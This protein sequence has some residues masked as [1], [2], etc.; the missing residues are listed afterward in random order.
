MIHVRELLPED[1]PAVARIESRAHDRSLTDGP[2]EHRERLTAALAESSNLSFGVFDDDE[3]VGYVLCYGFEPTAFADEQGNVL[4]VEDAAITPEYRPALPRLLKRFARHIHAYFPGVW[5]EAHA[6][7]RVLPIWR[8][9]DGL[10]ARHGFRFRRCEKTGE[11]LHGQARYALRWEPL[12]RGDTTAL[13]DMLAELP[14]H[15]P[16]PEQADD[17]V[18][19]VVRRESDWDVLEDVWDA[20]LLATPDHTAFQCYKYQR[21]WWRHFGGDS[22]LVIVLVLER[23]AIVGIAPLRTSVVRHYGR[24]RRELGFIGS[25]WQVDRPQLLFPEKASE[26]VRVLVDFLVRHERDWEIGDFYEQL[27]GSERTLSLADAFRAAGCLVGLER[28]SACPYIDLT[29][30]WMEFIA[31]K[32][33]KLRKNLKAAE[34]CL[35]EAG[36]LQY[37]TCDTFPEVAAE[38]ERYAA[39]EKRSWKDKEGVGVARDADYFAFYQEMAEVFGRH[40]AFVTRLLGVEGRDVAGTFGLVFDGVYYSLQISHDGELNRCSPGTLLE[41]RELEACFARGYREYEFLGGFLTNKS[42]WTSTF[43]Q[44]TQLHVYRRTPSLTLLHAW[45]FRIKPWIKE[46]IRPFMKSWPKEAPL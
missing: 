6:F 40:G 19:K 9:H 31:G 18:I 35:A 39:L 38:L 2:D 12:Q 13:Q 27:T 26:L 30:S 14:A 8:R 17:Y 3:L 28:D 33:Q 25:R 36:P 29:T 4:Y 21:L 37:R 22:E 23:N 34:R 24:Y 10:F 1:A 44:T 15:S 41:A 46:L 16:R 43:R 32:S 7:E 11:L 45:L 42:R 20:L 5:I